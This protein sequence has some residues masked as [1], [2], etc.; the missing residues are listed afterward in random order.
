MLPSSS[1]R[2]LSLL[3]LGAALSACSVGPDYRP[4]SAAALKISD[5]YATAGNRSS[6]TV[7]LATWWTRFDDPV[8]AQLVSRALEANNDIDAAEARLRAARASVK[9][10]QGALLPALGASTSA[11]SSQIVRGRGIDGDNYQLGLD[12]SWE[13]D[14]FGAN[15]R[16][17]EASRANAVGARASL[18]DVQRSIAAE[19]ALNYIEARNTQA[20]LAV[21]RANLGYQDET[22]QIAGWRVQAGLVS[23]LDVEQARVLRAQ[24]AASIPLLEQNYA[25]VTNRIAVLTGEAPG[26]VT[27]LLEAQRPIPL[28]TDAVELGLPADL[29]RRRPDVVASEAALAAE[30]AR[31]G[32]AQAQLYPALRLSGSLTSGSPTL[33]DLGS[34]ILGNLVGSLAAPIFQGGQLRAQVEGQRATADAALSNYRGTVLRALEDVENALVALDKAKVREDAFLVAESAARNSAIYARDRYR[35]G[36][37]DFQTLLEAERSLLSSQDSRTTARAARATASVQLYKALGGGWSPDDISGT[38]P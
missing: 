27:P 21:A 8:L 7:D 34:S 13:A 30:V 15:R 18:N 20:R 22:L 29:L 12:A 25:N 36:L 28:A 1:S 33:G 19:L 9:G 24:T 11:S 35:S 10:A 5:R 32:V 38:R 16:S 23:A 2:I 4:E 31:I 26:A 37:I 6:A 3:W 17:L 14:I